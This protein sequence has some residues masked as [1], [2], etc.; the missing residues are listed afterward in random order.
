[1]VFSIK[2]GIKKVL[3][4]QQS[5]LLM[6]KDEVLIFEID[7]PELKFNLTF[8]FS[9]EGDPFSTTFWEMPEAN[10]LKYQ[11]NRWDSNTWVEISKPI[12]LRVKDSTENFWLKF[13]NN[14]QSEKNIRKFEVTIWKE[15]QNG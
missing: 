8:S 1:M 4:Y 14:S 6:N 11:L 12:L 5:V 13:R 9:P 7:T 2:D 3:I 10:F 15:V